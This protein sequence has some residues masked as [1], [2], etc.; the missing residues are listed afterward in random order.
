MA[1]AIN[2]VVLPIANPT[3][4]AIQE[5]LEIAAE[6]ITALQAGGGA[7][8]S[9]GGVGTGTLPIFVGTLAELQ[10]YA[11]GVDLSHCLFYKT[12]ENGWYFNNQGDLT[13]L[14]ANSIGEGG[15]NYLPYFIATD[16]EAAV[17][18]PANGW[19]R[20]IFY[21]TDSST[22]KWII[23][24]TIVPVIPGQDFTGMMMSKVFDVTISG[25]SG[26]LTAAI[27]LSNLASS[28]ETTANK[29]HGAYLSSDAEYADRTPCSIR[30]G[31]PSMVEIVGVDM[32]DGTPAANGT[33]KLWVSYAL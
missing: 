19:Q 3:L 17:F 29:V 9:I 24:G 4:A 32:A 5:Q 21:S 18:A 15:I 26:N 20:S 16:A 8:G 1:S 11:G 13:P 22:F 7:G 25:G 14:Y 28:G 30:I 23:D 27:A 2:P 12:D 31:Y 10:A 33:Y 6:E